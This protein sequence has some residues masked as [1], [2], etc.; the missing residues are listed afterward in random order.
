MLHVTGLGGENLCDLVLEIRESA[1]NVVSVSNKPG[2]G[3]AFAANAEGHRPATQRNGPLPPIP[4]L[5][6]P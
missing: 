2:I 4:D 3:L 6:D 1:N 5:S